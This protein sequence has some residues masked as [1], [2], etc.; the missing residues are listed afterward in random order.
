MRGSGRSRPKFTPSLLI[1]IFSFRAAGKRRRSMLNKRS[2]MRSKDSE[3][4]DTAKRA[5][6]IRAALPRMGPW[7]KASW[8]SSICLPCWRVKQFAGSSTKM[9]G[10]MTSR[11]KDFSAVHVS[12]ERFITSG[13]IFQ[14]A[15]SRPNPSAQSKPTPHELR[16]G[17]APGQTDL[18]RAPRA[19]T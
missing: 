8:L 15:D 13:L 6:G 16:A 1:L 11:R 5:S 7:K 4:N 10:R 19:E 2:T 14:S 12:H 17:N 3:T 9:A 18:S